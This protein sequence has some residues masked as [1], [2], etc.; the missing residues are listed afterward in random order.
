MA[1]GLG[2]DLLHAAHRLALLGLGPQHLR[3]DQAGGHRHHRA[4]HQVARVDAEADVEGEHAA[5]DRRETADHDRVQ[6]A[7]RHALQER[8]DQQRRL[9]LADE[10]VRA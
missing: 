3:A 2:L 1:V 7:R 5:G 4:Y 6:F 8:P 10:H 9:G